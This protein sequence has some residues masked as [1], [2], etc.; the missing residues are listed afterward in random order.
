MGEG[1]KLQET[2]QSQ[3]GYTRQK[4]LPGLSE[5]LSHLSVLPTLLSSPPL[6]LLSLLQFMV[7]IP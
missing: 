6:D 7:F 2:N 5:K 1:R 4:R 3:G